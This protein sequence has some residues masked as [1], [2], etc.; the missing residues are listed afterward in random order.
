MNRYLQCIISCVLI[1]LFSSLIVLYA[2]DQ[3]NSEVLTVLSEELLKT[4]LDVWEEG[5]VIV[6]YLEAPAGFEIKRHYH[7]GEEFAYVIEGSGTTWFEDKPEVVVSKGD[8]VKIPYK[9]VHTFIPGPDGVKVLV[10]RVHKQ[11]E[12]IRIIVE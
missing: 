6:T 4:Q 8:I 2:Q 5:E 9:A 11:G 7:P 10:F 3:S 12:P 1:V